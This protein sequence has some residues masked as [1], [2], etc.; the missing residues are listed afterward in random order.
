MNKC[1][2]QSFMVVMCIF[3]LS[4]GFTDFFVKENVYEKTQNVI[5]D[6]QKTTLPSVEITGFESKELSE[7]KPY[8]FVSDDSDP[9]SVKA[10]VEE[11][12]RIQSA[13]NSDS[14]EG[15]ECGD[16]PPAPH[17]PFFLENYSLD[18]LAMTGTLSSPTKGKIALI[19]T[20]DSGIVNAAVGEY[21]GRQN[22]LIIAI[23]REVMIIQEK[24]RTAQG[25]Q[26]R[27]ASLPLIRN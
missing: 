5:S 10:F 27:N 4:T 17:A 14:C 13:E 8:H 15:D 2:P 25:W 20:P 12:G 16:G 11:V 7:Y 24:Y 3:T 22:G 6:I 26:N 18:Q 9:F 21:I 19:M 23:N 1:Q